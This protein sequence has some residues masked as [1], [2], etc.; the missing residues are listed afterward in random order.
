MRVSIVLYSHQYLELSIF[1]FQHSNKYIL[2]FNCILNLPFLI[3]MYTV[4][5]VLITD[6]LISFFVNFV[7]M[8][9][10]HLVSLLLFIVELWV[11]FLNSVYGLVDVFNFDF[12]L[13]F[14][15]HFITTFCVSFKNFPILRL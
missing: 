1:N 5:H 14:S 4:F 3:T 2:I 10:S 6:F 12:N 9:W 13:S 11:F 8:S 15:S 7:D